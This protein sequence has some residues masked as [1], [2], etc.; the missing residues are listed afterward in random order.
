MEYLNFMQI[1]ASVVDF[2]QNGTRERQIH[3]NFSA[4]PSSVHYKM[5]KIEEYQKG[6]QLDSSSNE[7]VD[8]QSI[9]IIFICIILFSF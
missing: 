9:I 2:P 7:Q 1:S 8:Y 4:P 5:P 6:F 3:R